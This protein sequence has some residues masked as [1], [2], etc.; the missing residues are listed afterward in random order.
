M[1]LAGPVTPPDREYYKTEFGIDLLEYEKMDDAHRGLDEI[2]AHVSGTRVIPPPV[3][4][5]GS[6][7]NTMDFTTWKAIP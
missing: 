7:L 4:G 3:F 6:L 1:L 5:F 2:L